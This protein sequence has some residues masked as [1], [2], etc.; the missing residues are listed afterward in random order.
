MA[1]IVCDFCR[2]VI[3]DSPVWHCWKKKGGALLLCPSCLSE[4]ERIF[5]GDRRNW[6]P[7]RPVANPWKLDRRRYRKTR[8]REL[9]AHSYHNFIVDRDNFQGFKEDPNRVAIHRCTINTQDEMRIPVDSS[10]GFS[11]RL[12]YLHLLMSEE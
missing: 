10:E 1:L 12:M 6:E 9:R 11:S 5:G 2:S 4:F 3:Q 7:F 8:E